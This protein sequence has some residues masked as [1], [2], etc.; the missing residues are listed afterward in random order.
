MEDRQADRR[1]TGESGRS[2]T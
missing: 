1:T 2:S